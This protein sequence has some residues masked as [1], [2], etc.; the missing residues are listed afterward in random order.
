MNFFSSRHHKT[1]YSV[2]TSQHSLHNRTCKRLEK[3]RG[4]NP[5]V[6]VQYL[7]FFSSSALN[8]ENISKMEIYNHKLHFSYTFR[9]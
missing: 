1:C 7:G 9:I 2:T 3:D 4:T 5:F 8:I 6:V